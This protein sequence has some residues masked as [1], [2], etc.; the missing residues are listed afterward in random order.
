MCYIWSCSHRH[1]TINVSTNQGNTR[2]THKGKHFTCLGAILFPPI[3]LQYTL[4][5]TFDEAKKMMPNFVKIKQ[6]Y[7]S[8]NIHNFALFSHPKSFYL[9]QFSVVSCFSGPLNGGAMLLSAG[10]TVLLFPNMC[11][12]WILWS[13]HHVIQ[14]ITHG[15]TSMWET[16]TGVVCLTLCQSSTSSFVIVS[17]TPGHFCIKEVTAIIAHFASATMPSTTGGVLHYTCDLR[18][19]NAKWHKA[20]FVWFVG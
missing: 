15:L 3:F 19:C 17:G 9:V 7:H 2:S 10:Q 16:D 12:T 20:H 8:P 5:V 11:M 18:H 1:E 6:Y 14:E 4:N 13:D